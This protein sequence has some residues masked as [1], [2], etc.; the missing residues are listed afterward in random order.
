MNAAACPTAAAPQR[1]RM[2]RPAHN[3]AL[4]AALQP[5]ALAEGDKLPAAAQLVE[6]HGFE[7]CDSG[8]TSPPMLYLAPM[9]RDHGRWL[10]AR[11][12]KELAHALDLIAKT[13]EHRAEVMA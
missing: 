6:V 4:P 10:T 7:I 1:L 8:D 11:Q 12:A 9:G 3:H 13:M 2:P 5:W